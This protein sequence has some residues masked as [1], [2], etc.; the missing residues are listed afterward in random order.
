MNEHYFSDDGSYGTATGMII[1]DTEKWTPDMW[2]AI[3]E[4]SDME[5]SGVA[6]HFAS[7]RHLWQD[8]MCNKCGLRPEQVDREWSDK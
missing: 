1:V 8:E 2:D 4:S 3:I 5:R 6:L 7:G